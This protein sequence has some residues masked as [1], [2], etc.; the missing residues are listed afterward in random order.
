MPRSAVA[1]VTVTSGTHSLEELL[2]IRSTV[3]RRRG[4]QR[5]SAGQNQYERRACRPHRAQSRVLGGIGVFS[6]G[7]SSVALTKG[8]SAGEA[9]RSVPCW[10]PRTGAS[11]TPKPASAAKPIDHRQ[12]APLVALPGIPLP[13]VA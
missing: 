9:E 1:A 12:A 7:A 6:H 11:G 8:H 5:G 4:R 13:Q 3:R 2:A 10:Y